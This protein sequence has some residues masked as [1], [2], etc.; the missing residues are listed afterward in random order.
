MCA[1]HGLERGTYREA[2]LQT[3]NG[4]SNSMYRSGTGSRKTLRST[5]LYLTSS[6]RIESGSC[7]HN[8]MNGCVMSSVVVAR[9]LGSFCMHAATKLRNSGE[10]F[11]ATSSGAGRSTM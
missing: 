6:A 11:S 2:L 3:L 4:C 5:M 10:Y 7:S 8:W 1:C 9:F